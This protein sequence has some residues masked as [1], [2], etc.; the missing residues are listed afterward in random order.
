M[1]DDGRMKCS[2]MLSQNLDCGHEISY[3]CGQKPGKC[4]FHFPA[5]RLPCGHL[6]APTCAEKAA[7]LELKCQHP[8]A[9]LP[10]PCGHF[11]DIV[12]SAT[13]QAILCEEECGAALPCGHTCAQP[14]STCQ[15]TKEH[16]EC[17]K[18]C[19]ESLPCGH[20]CKQPCHEGDCGP[21]QQKCS[22]GCHHGSCDWVCST[23]CDPCIKTCEKQSCKHQDICDG[24]CSLPCAQLPC[25]EPCNRPLL[26]G[27][28]LCYSLCGETC[29][30]ECIQCVSG[31][32]PSVRQITLDCGHCFPVTELDEAFHIKDLYHVSPSGE[33]EAG[34]VTRMPSTFGIR[35]PECWTPV[36][37]ARRYIL[38]NQLGEVPDTID[39]LYCK[40]GRKLS[41]YVTDIFRSEEYLGVTFDGF[42]NQVKPGPLAGKQNQ[43]LVWDRTNQMLE[44]QQILTKYRDE[45]TIPIEEY[46]AQLA[47]FIDNENILTAA[48]LPYRLRFDLLYFRCRL[49]TLE[50]GLKMFHYLDQLSRLDKHTLIMAEAL[51]FKILEQS[52]GEI[53]SLGERIEECEK[54]HLIRLE[55]ELR[56]VQLCLHMILANLSSDSGIDIPASKK[57]VSDLCRRF[58]DTAGKLLK[59]FQ[60]LRAYLDGGPAPKRLY[61]LYSRDVRELWWNY[62]KHKVGSLCHCPYGHPYS[63]PTFSECPECGREVELELPEPQVNVEAIL[64][65]NAF[66]AHFGIGTK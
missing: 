55:V 18:L 21:C 51:K 65:K 46:V 22:R 43:R 11:K 9:K 15:G 44:V 47:T 39:R 16:P 6:Y 64:N 62:G 42:C 2:Q 1:H 35:C 59:S 4:T 58:P 45:V 53:E 33:I 60:L 10:L 38:A 63:E 24:L 56:L 50:D 27:L 13:R 8:I 12:C 57:R 66:L 19:G 23:V 17:Q 49:I 61:D 7:G 37:K 52:T 28:H 5:L 34:G 32:A 54:R 30:S 26:C 3:K 36:V 25:S 41:N 29:P 14:C 48:V 31:S 20:D 40:L